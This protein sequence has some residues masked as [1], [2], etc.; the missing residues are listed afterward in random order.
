MCEHL[1]IYT[2]QLIG[3]EK[4]NVATRE[5]VCTRVIM[6]ATKD[7]KQPQAIGKAGSSFHSNS[8]MS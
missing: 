1:T 5:V 2:C 4:N 6:S 8:Q 3:G 7:M